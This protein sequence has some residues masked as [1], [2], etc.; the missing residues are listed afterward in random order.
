MIDSKKL[1]KIKRYLEVFYYKVSDNKLNNTNLY[2]LNKNKIDN[3]I[4]N[5]YPEIILLYMYIKKNVN[6]N[7]DDIKD[8]YNKIETY[9]KLYS[10]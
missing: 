7:N 1:D 10:C 6:N 2:I 8:K 4:N 9:Y 3:Y 5:D